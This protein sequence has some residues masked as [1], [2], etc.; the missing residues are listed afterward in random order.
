MSTTVLSGC[1]PE[2]LAAYL[3]SLAVLRLVGEGVD[4]QAKGWWGEG[5]F[6]LESKLDPDD[7]VRFFLRDYC[8]TALVAPWGA[9]SGFFPRKLREVGA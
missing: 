7:L 9:R 2:P 3:R 1:S 5:G 6:C 4:S 8:P